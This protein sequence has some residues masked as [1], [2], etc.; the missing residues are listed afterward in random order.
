MI[1]LGDMVRKNHPLLFWGMRRL[2]KAKRDAIYTLFAFCRHLATLQRSDM[3]LTE[4]AEILAA[5]HEELN[6]IYDKRV[7]E[8]NI[9]RKIYKNCL[10]FNLPKKLWEE[11]LNSAELDAQIPL[12]APDE[13]KFIRYVDGTAVVPIELTLMILDGEHPLV[14]AELAKNL[15]YAVL[16]TYIL[17]DIKDDAKR[18]RM[19]IPLGAL[20]EC[21]IELDTPRGIIENKNLSAVRENIATQV[22]K[23]YIQA[24]K[25]LDKTNKQD[26][27]PLHMVEVSGRTLFEMMKKRGWEIISP[28]PQLGFIKRVGIAYRLLFK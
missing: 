9:G 15:G 20:R 27:L 3:S 19:Y 26:T 13:N 14:N 18:G 25:L 1:S 28:K 16:L 7:P 21:G 17:R 12:V 24:E 2:P 5:W 11:I 4:K 10:R 23:C 6:N 22:E 8:T